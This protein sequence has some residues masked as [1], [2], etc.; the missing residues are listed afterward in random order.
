M[1]RAQY[2]TKINVSLKNNTWKSQEGYFYSMVDGTNGFYIECDLF[3]EGDHQ[4]FEKL[5]E[6]MNIL[7]GND[8]LD[9]SFMGIIKDLSVVIRSHNKTRIENTAVRSSINCYG[10]QK[11]NVFRNTILTP[12]SFVKVYSSV[13]NEQITLSK[14]DAVYIPNLREHVRGGHKYWDNVFFMSNDGVFSGADDII[15]N[16]VTD[17]TPVEYEQG[18]FLTNNSY[19]VLSPEFKSSFKASFGLG[20]NRDV[21]NPIE[22]NFSNIT[23]QELQS[24]VCWCESFSTT[25]SK[26]IIIKDRPDI[27]K[28]FLD[29][30]SITFKDYN[31]NE[32]SLKLAP[33][34]R[35]ICR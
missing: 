18:S 12:E 10:S 16:S 6:E 35:S 31:I 33:D 14:G 27:Q 29:S 3:L 28:Y 24:M 7:E 1:Q 21:L 22:L 17:T 15:N 4:D 26:K 20:I 34:Y 30:F 32:F 23:N 8:H 13:S 2:K 11:S 25:K 9:I 5:V 19:D